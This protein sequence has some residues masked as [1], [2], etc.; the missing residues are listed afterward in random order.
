LTAAFALLDG[1]S[2]DMPLLDLSQ[3]VPGYP[4]APEIVRRVAEAAHERDAMSYTARPGLPELRSLFAADIAAGY[5]GAVEPEEVLITAGANQAFCIA[6]STLADVGD[7]V[8]IAAPY[9]F[10]HATWL[11]MERISPRFL[12]TD[13][14]FLPDP[15]D[16][17]EL[18][19]DRT[20]AI[21]LVTPSNPTGV[22]IP[23]EVLDAF[24]DI[25]E[26][27]EIVLILDETYRAF[28]RADGPPHRL[29]ARPNWQRWLVSVHS[30]S[31]EFAIPGFRV[32]AAVGGKDLLAEMLKLLDCVAICAPRLGQEA[33]IA[34]L[35]DAQ[36]WRVER[37]R[38]I[39]DKERIFR[40]VMA[41]APGGFELSS[42]GAFF[43]WVRHPF[44]GQTAEDVVARL[45]TDAGILA[46][47][48]SL[49][50]LQDDGYVRFSFANLSADEIREF[51]K[52]LNG[53][54]T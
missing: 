53:F 21:V 9:Y 37:V 28:R 48:G 27:R 25:A 36:A 22:T 44:S 10:N 41:D 52:R 23:S 54:N 32:G 38:E 7:E 3:G 13:A 5:E 4:T 42:A 51:G 2:E 30:F 19:T 16:A 15:S 14:S 29:F 40:A 49:F 33:A 11:R 35:T 6:A 8:I 24:A 26:R 46:L 34:G 20:R 17:E 45:A 39:R 12:E 43:G 50:T 47:P 18:L 31:K 1:R